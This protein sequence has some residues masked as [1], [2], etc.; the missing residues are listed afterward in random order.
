MTLAV[1]DT[2]HRNWRQLIDGLV[3]EWR[4]DP[5]DDVLDLRVEQTATKTA[6]K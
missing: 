4:T 2:N 5:D 3:D 6:T 1:N